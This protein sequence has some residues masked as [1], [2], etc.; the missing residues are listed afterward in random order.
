MSGSY[1]IY[2]MSR[3]GSQVFM[4][5]SALDGRRG[6]LQE[7]YSFV[8]DPSIYEAIDTVYGTTDIEKGK[9]AYTEL[10]Q[11]NLENFAVIPLV[12]TATLFGAID[13]IQNASLDYN[14]MQCMYGWLYEE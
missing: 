3:F 11:W 2:L 8:D 12:E 7:N 10:M 1:D 13:T 9:A 4:T 6:P 5:A 14:G